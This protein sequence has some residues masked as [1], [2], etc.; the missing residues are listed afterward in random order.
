MKKNYKM[1]NLNRT[2]IVA[3]IGPASGNVGVLESMIANGCSVFRINFSHGSHESHG[4]SIANIRE[5]A[6]NLGQ[7]VAILGDL[8][9]P[10]IRVLLVIHFH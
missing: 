2:K 3:T 10:K 8:Q 4:Q 7:N 5:A 9:G 1:N 6:A